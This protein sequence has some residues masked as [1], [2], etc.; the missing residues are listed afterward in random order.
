MNG[1]D[2]M[3]GDYDDCVDDGWDCVECDNEGAICVCIDDMCRGSDPQGCGRFGD[4]SCYRL[5]PVCRGASVS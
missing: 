4:P 1:V 5:C 2:P 3:T